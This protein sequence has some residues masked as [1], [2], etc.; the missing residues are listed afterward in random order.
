MRYLIVS[1][2]HG[3]V[4]ST[5]ILIKK[6][7]E[8]ECKKIILLGDILSYDMDANAKIVDMLNLFKNDVIAVKGNGE[9]HYPNP[10]DFELRDHFLITNKEANFLFVHG[11][12]L[13]SNID[14]L[15]GVP[16]CYIVHGHTHRVRTYKSGDINF[17]NIGSIALPRGSSEKCFGVFENNH[18]K[19]YTLDNKI[20]TEI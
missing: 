20:I 8:F 3:D 12:E 6:Y 14:L 10:F 4:E 2:L 11:H 7:H 17:I 5:K 13:E 15:M 18:I 9:R 19:I 1:D 16:H